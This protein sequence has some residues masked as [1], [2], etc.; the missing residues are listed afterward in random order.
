MKRVPIKGFEGCYEIDDKGNIDSLERYIKVNDHGRVYLKHIK[1]CKLVWCIDNLGYASVRLR[2]ESDGQQKSY[3]IHRLVA[4]AFIPN[5]NNLPMVNHKDEN[6]QNNDVKNLEWCTN[7]Y[8][9]NYGTAR[10]RQANALKQYYRN[11][12]PNWGETPP[13]KS[14]PVWGK[15]KDEESWVKYGSMLE[16]SQALGCCYNTVVKSVRGLPTRYFEFK[17]VGEN[18]NG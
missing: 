9:L 6:R 8:N 15:R 5:P 10:E 12:T 7:R 18:E 4:E 2:R 11:H 13:H 16:A 3:R 17:T 14:I 1:P